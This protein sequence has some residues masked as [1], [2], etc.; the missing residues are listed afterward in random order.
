MLRS[1]YGKC[2][3]DPTVRSIRF[4]D[5]VHCYA[6]PRAENR[7]QPEICCRFVVTVTPPLVPSFELLYPNS[8]QA[9][10]VLTAREN[11]Q[12]IRPAS[13]AVEAMAADHVKAIMTTNQEALRLP[14][15]QN[16]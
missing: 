11:R 15:H 10:V 13:R 4:L 7:E 1:Q 3:R 16:T 14:S 2:S 6:P 8:P 9:S 12:T 5:Q